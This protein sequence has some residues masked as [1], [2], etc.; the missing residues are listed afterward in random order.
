MYAKLKL[1]CAHMR[2]LRILL[3]EQA[4]KGLC[5][6][7]GG[8]GI[9][10]KFLGENSALDCSSVA[11]IRRKYQLLNADGFVGNVLVF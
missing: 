3:R 2:T 10:N 9:I 4:N 6:D 11:R 1:L 5:W 7:L 8:G